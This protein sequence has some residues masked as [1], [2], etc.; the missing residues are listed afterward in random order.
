MSTLRADDLGQLLFIGLDEDRWSAALEKRLRTIRPGGIVFTQR[1]LRTPESTVELLARIAG[2]VDNPPFLA[3]EEEGGTVDPLRKFFPPLSSPRAVAAMGPAAA[4]QLGGLAGAGLNLLGFNTNFAPLLDLATGSSNALIST[5]SFGSDG[6]QVANCSEAF[7]RGL[8]RH[9]ILACAK[10]F[11]GLGDARPDRDTGILLSGKP[12]ARMWREDLVPYRKLLPQLALVIVSHCAYKAYDFDFALRAPLSKNVLEGLLRVKLGYRGVVL[13]DYFG[14][15]EEI[16]QRM[17]PSAPGRPEKGIS[18][19]LEAFPKSVAAGI[20]MLVVRWG[21][22]APELVTER[23]ENALDLGTV[24]TTRVNEAL[25]RIRRVKKG[26]RLPTGKFSTQAFERLSREFEEFNK[27][28]C[29]T[30]GKIA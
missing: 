24:T 26:L 21:G 11:P 28:C 23:L 18:L 14:T 15:G 30:G 9:K 22:R 1:N 6:Q 27:E 4:R 5:R 3:L 19:N 16:S 12:M 20:D 25:K 17:P 29:S 8:H 2:T 10:H 13:A 7:V